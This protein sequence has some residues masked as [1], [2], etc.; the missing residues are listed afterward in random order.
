MVLM[1]TILDEEDRD[2]SSIS[3]EDHDGDE[4]EQYCSNEKRSRKR[5]E[6]GVF[7]DEKYL[8]RKQEQEISHF[9]KH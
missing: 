1:K 6:T 3:S 4:R 7:Y 8:E 2:T 9:I 5:G